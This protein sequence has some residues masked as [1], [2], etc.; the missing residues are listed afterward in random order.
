MRVV[1]CPDSFKGSL[2][3][4]EVAK[5]IAKAF[6]EVDQTI[7][8]DCVPI[9]DGGEGTIDAFYASVGGQLK[10][11]TVN[12]PMHELIK[13]QYLVL[14]DNI[15]VIEMAQSTGLHL[16]KGALR[17][18]LV[19]T[20][21]GM[22]ETIRHALDAGYR[23]FVVGIG[24]SATNDGGYGL[25]RA[26]GLRFYDDKG[27]ELAGDVLAL[28]KLAH[29]DATHFDARV[30]EST[31]HIAC[32][33]NNPLLGK[34]GA[35]AVFGPQKGVT[36]EMQEQLEQALA[37]LAKCIAKHVGTAVHEIAGAGA[38]GGV[39]MALLAYFP[40]TF[41]NGIDV[42]SLTTGLKEKIAQADYVITGEGHSDHQ[43]LNGKAPF[44]IAKLAKQQGISAV[45]LSGKVAKESMQELQPYFQM[46]LSVADEQ[47]STSFAMNH[48]V[49][50]L[51]T[52]AK[53][54][55]QQLKES[56]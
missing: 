24:G 18:P 43:T 54:L 20:S 5:I 3:A 28:K 34:N 33:V 42:I 51:F 44:G 40:V 53:E 38:A 15:C 4:I 7:T 6:H 55:A 8:V 22:G 14:P 11:V 48:A 12:N 52:R 41:T 23:K 17:N 32:D 37:Q 9:A 21:Y 10:E 25:L 29:I 45:L 30:G 2:S 56:T 13:V 27:E 35:T 26:M 39:G 46:I 16:V 31:W 19:A 1:V 36:K 47:M 50:L 49:D